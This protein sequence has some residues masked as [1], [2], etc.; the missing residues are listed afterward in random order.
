MQPGDALL[1]AL[2]HVLQ[3]H[4]GALPASLLGDELRRRSPELWKAW[5]SSEGDT[6]GES[7]GNMVKTYFN[8]MCIYKCVFLF[9]YKCLCVCIKNMLI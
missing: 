9:I 3:L 8:A 5:K 4:G 7:G 2:R 1:A 6:K